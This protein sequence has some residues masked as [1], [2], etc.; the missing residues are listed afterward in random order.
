M[1]RGAFRIAFTRMHVSRRLLD[2]QNDIGHRFQLW[3]KH[4]RAD[5]VGKSMMMDFGISVSLSVSSHKEAHRERRHFI[6]CNGSQKFTTKIYCTT[7]V[8]Q[9]KPSPDG[10]DAFQDDKDDGICYEVCPYPFY[11]CM[12]VVKSCNH[13]RIVYR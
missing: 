12:H 7:Q 10:C 3:T 4:A 9:P 8:E 11:A 2:S 6:V 13:K 1:W 5:A